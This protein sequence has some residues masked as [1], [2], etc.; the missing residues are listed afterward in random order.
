MGKFITALNDEAV[1]D[2][3]PQ[4]S[5]LS[6]G[7]LAYRHT[8]KALEVANNDLVTYT[9]RVYN[10]GEVGG[11]AAEIGDNIP[12]GLVFVKD[13]VTNVAYGWKMYDKDGKET[14]DIKQAVEVRTDYLSKEKGEAR[15]VDTLIKAYNPNTELSTDPENA[16]PDFRDVKLVFRV[17]EKEVDSDRT[18]E[19]IAE[20]T[21]DRDEDNKPVEDED[22]VPGNDDLDEDDI[23]TEKVIVKYFDLSLV[24]YVTRVIVT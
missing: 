22:S 2:R 15:G 8:A 7:T 14:T 5:K 6:D 21:D 9:I 12:E 17:D 1:T 23:D 20:I 4:I 11:Y 19:N 24:K 13:N 3:V 18:I 16:N 10:E